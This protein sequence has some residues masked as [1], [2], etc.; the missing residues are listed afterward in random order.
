MSTLL[1]EIKSRGY[2]QVIIRPCTFVQYRVPEISAL[3]P[4]LQK[5]SVGSRGWS[6][7]QVRDPHTELHI[8]I[9]WVGQ[10]GHWGH[11]LEVWRF[12]QSGQFVDFSGMRYDWLDISKS[13]PSGQSWKPGVFWGIG[14]AVFRFTEIF[15][16]AARLALTEAGD[17]QMHIE[18]T[19]SGLQGRVLWVDSP[20]RFPMPRD[21]R[22]SIKEFPYIV[23]L[24]RTELIAAPRELALKP[25][26]ELFQRFNWN[27]PRELL[28]G[29]QEELRRS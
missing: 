11:H 3:Y 28:Q 25:A 20:N 19:V 8:D 6:F 12:Y 26:M 27:P 24:P 21:Y 18:V 2:W 15:E 9:D 14:D 13:L 4:I 7:P 29:V 1:Q 17:E 10:E 16:F 22:A 23:E 5:T